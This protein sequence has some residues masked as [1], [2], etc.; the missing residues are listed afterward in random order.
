MVVAKGSLGTKFHYF[1]LEHG[2]GFVN[3]PVNKKRALG[4]V[5]AWD[6]VQVKGD[7][8][9]LKHPSKPDEFLVV[10]GQHRVY[11][12][13]ESPD[14]PPLGRKVTATIHDTINDFPS[15]ATACKSRNAVHRYFYALNSKAPGSILGAGA[16]TDIAIRSGE[17]KW[18]QPFK[19]AGLVD[20]KGDFIKPGPTTLSSVMNMQ[21]RLDDCLAKGRVTQEAVKRNATE[22]MSYDPDMAKVQKMAE[23]LLWWKPIAVA[24]SGATKAS[25]GKQLP[26]WGIN[27]MP[28]VYLIWAQNQDKLATTLAE[29]EVVDS[30]LNKKPYKNSQTNLEAIKEALGRGDTL[31][32]MAMQKSV[33]AA[34]NAGIRRADENVPRPW[35][36]TLFGKTDREL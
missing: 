21:I 34:F 6:V 23:F 25:K 22:D 33:H 16:S 2:F 29:T 32:T 1:K 15:T 5:P 13:S 8:V 9:L 14:F 24:L 31:K 12:L 18:L 4:L 17:N 35:E 11:A 27:I 30:F 10:D 26:W 3:R 20:A 19:A 36:V 28:I 7:L